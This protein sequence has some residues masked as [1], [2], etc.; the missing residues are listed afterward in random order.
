VPTLAGT[1]SPRS[2]ERTT[3]DEVRRLRDDETAACSGR[4]VSR[5]DGVGDRLVV[6]LRVV[7]A[8]GACE[9]E[10]GPR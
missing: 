7:A 6:E 4:D 8:D 1:R 9:L 5:G 10:L 2:P 3:F